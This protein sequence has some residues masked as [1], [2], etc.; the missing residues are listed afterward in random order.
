MSI[1]INGICGSRILV[2]PIQGVSHMILTNTI[3]QELQ[4]RGHEVKWLFSIVC[5][6]KNRID[7]EIMAH[8]NNDFFHK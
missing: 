8:Y 5:E 3:G 7:C 6:E 1:L 2:L 4:S